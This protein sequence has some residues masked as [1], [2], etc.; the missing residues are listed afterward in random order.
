MNGRDDVSTGIPIDAQNTYANSFVA[1]VVIR[2]SLIDLANTVNLIWRIFVAFVGS[3]GCIAFTRVHIVGH[4]DCWKFNKLSEIHLRK[5][6]SLSLSHAVE[7]SKSTQHNQHQQRR[8][9]KDRKIN[10]SHRPGVRNSNF[11]TSKWRGIPYHLSPYD[12][13]CHVARWC[14]S[15]TCRPARTTGSRFRSNRKFMKRKSKIC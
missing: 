13:R 5:S 4:V 12:V 8:P 2:S 6:L 9:A 14:C 3:A 11:L 1:F 10:I 15:R 7:K